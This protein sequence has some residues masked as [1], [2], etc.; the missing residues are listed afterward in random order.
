MNQT[1]A[2]NQEAADDQ[3]RLDQT[4]FYLDPV[5]IRA[6]RQALEAPTIETESNLGL[7]RLLAITP[8]WSTKR[9]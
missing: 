9:T 2:S 4:T 3:D 8:P 6:F 5:Q 1:P 7:D